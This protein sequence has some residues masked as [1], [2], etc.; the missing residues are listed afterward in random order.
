MWVVEQA[1][2]G[3]A[4]IPHHWLDALPLPVI[5]AFTGHGF[6]LNMPAG[7]ADRGFTR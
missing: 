2:H 5:T 6:T 7:D 3:V 4:P 1:A